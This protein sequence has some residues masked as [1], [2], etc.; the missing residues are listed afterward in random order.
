[1]PI[2]KIILDRSF[3]THVQQVAESL[4]PKLSQTIKQGLA[5]L[6]ATPQVMLQPG[7]YVSEP[8]KIYADLLFR[9]SA[10]RTPKHVNTLLQQLADILSA[11]FNTSVRLRAFPTDQ[12]TLSAVDHLLPKD[13]KTDQ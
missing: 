11:E 7:C 6:H 9:G 12:A 4:I 10:Q 5:P 8:Y 2:M 3:D 13:H 1:M